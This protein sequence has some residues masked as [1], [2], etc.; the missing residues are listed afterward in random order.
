MISKV[1]I[2]LFGYFWSYKVV[3]I[4]RLMCHSD[5]TL[6][7]WWWWSGRCGGYKVPVMVV[8]VVVD[9]VVITYL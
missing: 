5:A 8:V 3:V 1:W 9:V 6:S 7:I 2:I 4:Y